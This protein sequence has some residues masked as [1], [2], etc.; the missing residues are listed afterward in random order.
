MRTMYATPARVSTV[1]TVARLGDIPMRMMKG[2]ARRRVPT[3]ACTFVMRATRNGAASAASATN[4]SPD[5]N[6]M[7][8]SCVCACRPS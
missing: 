1:E 4:S 5:A 2:T 8:M 6:V 7:P 3:I